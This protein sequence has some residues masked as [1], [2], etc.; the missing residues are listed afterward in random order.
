M[1]DGRHAVVVEGKLVEVVDAAHAGEVG[2][3]HHR[4]GAVAL[5]LPL[6]DGVSAIHGHKH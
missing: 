3:A 1:E 4:V 2:G 6:V 5:L